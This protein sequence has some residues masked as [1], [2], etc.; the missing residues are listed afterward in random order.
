[1]KKMFFKNVKMLKMFIIVTQVKHWV[2]FKGTS[3]RSYYKRLQ[4]TPKI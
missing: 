1:M 4:R 2:N 3:K